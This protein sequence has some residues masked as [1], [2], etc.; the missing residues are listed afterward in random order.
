MGGALS[1]FV[2]LTAFVLALS[3]DLETI[4]YAREIVSILNEAGWEVPPSFGMMYR[5]LL[6][7]G[8]EAV[9][10]GVILGSLRSAE[11]IRQFDFQR[12][13]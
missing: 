4:E 11:P 3:S 12:L 2:G 5:R 6:Q 8:R 9:P 13:P 7:P 10:P 1:D